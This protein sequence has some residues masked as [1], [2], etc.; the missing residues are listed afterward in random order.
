MGSFELLKHEDLGLHSRFKM[1]QQH[2]REF[3]WKIK[4]FQ[5]CGRPKIA[6]FIDDVAR[7]AI[8]HLRSTADVLESF[9]SLTHKQSLRQQLDWHLKRA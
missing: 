4:K 7:G 5:V 6:G 9:A 2:D 3:G 1:N 8:T